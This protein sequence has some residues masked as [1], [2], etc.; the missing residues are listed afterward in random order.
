M[1]TLSLLAWTEHFASAQLVDAVCEL[2]RFGYH[3]LWLPERVGR[4]L[5]STCGY[6]LAKTSS[7]RV[8]CGI[9]NIYVRDADAVAQGRQTLAELSADRFSLG[10]GV[11]HRD[12]IEPRGHTWEAPVKKMRA[13]LE[14]IQSAPLEGPA[15]T[16]PAPIII[17]AH[18]Q[19]LWGVAAEHTDGILTNCLLPETVSRARAALGPD[20]QIHSLV[21][22]VLEEDPQRARNAVRRTVG[23]YLGLPAYHR[24]WAREGFDESDW[25]N[26]GSDRLIDALSAWGNAPQISARLAEFEAAGSSHIVM[27]GVPAE[28]ASDP[29]LAKHWDWDLLRALAPNGGRS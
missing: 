21:R 26:G 24:A 23:L 10:L 18:G 27:V 1:T 28:T 29:H 3:E 12:L 5:F 7:L 16:T 17:A 13:Y 22:C 8:S 15:P 6:L 19:G 2:E 14:R 20:K 4:E 11:S 9:A 25:S